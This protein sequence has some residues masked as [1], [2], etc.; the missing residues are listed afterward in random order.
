MN[1]TENN[2]ADKFNFYK[3]YE[4]I[5]VSLIA[6]MIGYLLFFFILIIT[7]WVTSKFF[8][9]GTFTL[10]ESDFQISSIG[11]ATA[12]FYFYFKYARKNLN[13]SKQ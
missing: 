12:F 8:N 9:I 11:F 4:Y 2:E 5:F 7:Y 6:G 1:N 3:K 10:N 13:S